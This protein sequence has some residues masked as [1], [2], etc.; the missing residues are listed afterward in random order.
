ME[1]LI[2][3]QN[4]A[5]TELC[6]RLNDRK[7][8]AK[9]EESD[10]GKILTVLLPGMPDQEEL[11]TDIFFYTQDERMEQVSFCSM[12]GRGERGRVEPVAQREGA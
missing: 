4:K 11:Y 12:Y 9:I 10:A 6:D 8:A 5:L 3:E 7:V 1:E 2:Q